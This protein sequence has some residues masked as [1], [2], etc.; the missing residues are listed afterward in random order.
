MI[1]GITDGET[2]VVTGVL[3][4]LKYTKNLY[5][6]GNMKMAKLV[7][8]NYAIGFERSLEMKEFS[9]LHSV[10]YAAGE[11]KQGTISLIVS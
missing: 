10:A 9:Y 8:S 5:Y 4:I 2:Y 1:I 6:L 7:S 3:A 11:L